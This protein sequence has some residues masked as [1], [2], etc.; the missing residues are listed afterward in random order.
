MAPGYL[1]EPENCSYPFSA[2]GE[3]NLPEY[4][5]RENVFQMIILLGVVKSR[6]MEDFVSGLLWNQ[7]LRLLKTVA[8]QTKACC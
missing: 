3:C 1:K 2:G 8:A 5:C 6:S 4:F 7:N